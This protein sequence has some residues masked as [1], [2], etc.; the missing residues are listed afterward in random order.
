MMAKIQGKNKILHQFRQLGGAM[1]IRV[2]LALCQI[3][4]DKKTN[5]F[6]KSLCPSFVNE[7]IIKL[8]LHSGVDT[9]RYIEGAKTKNLAR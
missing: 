4:I 7:L 6:P 1:S 2:A 9:S 8:P 3:S 5:F